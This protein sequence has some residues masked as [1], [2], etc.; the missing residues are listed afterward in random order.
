MNRNLQPLQFHEY[1]G[2][3]GNPSH[4]TRTESGMLPTSVIAH[5]MGA[6]GEKPGEHRNRQGA[7]WYDFKGKIAANGMKNPLFITKDHGEDPKLSEGSHRRDAALE[8]GMPHVPVEIR[9][10]GHSERQGLVR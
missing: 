6:S 9:Y 4:V 1:E 2:Q 8:L 10:Y 3:E 5:L 7:D